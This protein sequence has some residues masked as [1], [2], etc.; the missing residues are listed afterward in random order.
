LSGILTFTS[1]KER[2]LVNQQEKP[3]VV[4]DQR[5]LLAQDE[6]N[7]SQLQ[8]DCAHRK[9]RSQGPVHWNS[10]RHQ[11]VFGY[12]IEDDTALAVSALKQGKKATEQQDP[13]LFLIAYGESVILKPEK[14]ISYHLNLTWSAP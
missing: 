12:L 14:T 11:A 2:D 10:R 4:R 9:N 3:R 7:H 8:R 13:Q 6:R 5:A 1:A